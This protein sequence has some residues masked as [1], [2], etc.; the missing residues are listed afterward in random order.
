MCTN[1][2][3]SLSPEGLPLSVFAFSQPSR[4]R[5]PIVSGVHLHYVVDD[6]CVGLLMLGGFVRVFGS[7][8]RGG[9]RHVSFAL[10]GFLLPRPLPFLLRRL[11]VV[12][13]QCR[14]L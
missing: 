6:A 4:F 8:A 9:L 10:L 5:L 13:F 11:A 1:F 7:L 12:A 2:M 14:P 3:M